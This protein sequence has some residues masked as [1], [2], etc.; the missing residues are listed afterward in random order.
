MPVPVVLGHWDVYELL[1]RQRSSEERPMAHS[2]LPNLRKGNVRIVF[3][4]VGGDSRSHASGSDKFLRG[5]LHSM[6][7]AMSALEQT[8]GCRVIRSRADLQLLSGDDVGFLLVLEGGRPLDGDLATLRQFFRL[9]IRCLLLT[10]NG[11]NELGDGVGEGTTAG[12]LS[13]FGREVVVEMRKLGMVLDLSHLAERGFYDAVDLYDGPVVATHS[14]S[15]KLHDHPRNLTD[16]QI[17]RV[18]ETGG[19]V[20][21]AFM[22]AFLSERPTVE[23]VVDHIEHI[24]ELVGADHV[25][26]G[27]DFSYAPVAE[28]HKRQRKYE[29]IRVDLEVPYPIADASELPKLEEALSRRGFEKDDLAKVLG[30][31]FDRV[32]LD[33]LPGESP[34]HEK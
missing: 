9:G 27:P 4:A 28:E 15:R 6:D 31:N 8:N 33:V 16:D 1:H 29:G 24:A 12:G 13:R 25:G 23:T 10:W 19:V 7:V 18:A 22:P 26:I 3:F 5:T 34:A 17:R 32:L 14:N 11:R 2:I 30:T 21:V 20:G